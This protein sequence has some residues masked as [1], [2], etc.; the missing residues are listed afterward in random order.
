MLAQIIYLTLDLEHN[1]KK[2]LRRIKKPEV[3][4]LFA[5]INVDSESKGFINYQ[6][7]KKFLSEDLRMNIAMIDLM[8]LLKRLDRSKNGVVVKE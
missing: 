8:S 5:E 4:W 1:L 3:E 6:E 2:I 7:L